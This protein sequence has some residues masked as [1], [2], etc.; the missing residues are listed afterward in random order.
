M[1]TTFLISVFGF[2]SLFRIFDFFEN[3]FLLNTRWSSGLKMGGLWISIL[4]NFY[5]F[6]KPLFALIS[7]SSV[8]F[9]LAIVFYFL[10][11]R[12]RSMFEI[13]SIFFLDLLIL[14]LQMGS[15][16][17]VSFRN[18]I[19]LRPQ[20]IHRIFK[21]ILDSLVQEI[22]SKNFAM[23]HFFGFYEQMI[24]IDQTKTK[25]I[26]R[27]K[28]LRG[29]FLRIQRLKKRSFQI[30]Q[31]VGF[32]SL[33]LSL[34]YFGLMAFVISNFGFLKNAGLLMVSLLIYLVGVMGVF[35]LGV[36]RKW[37]V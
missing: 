12:R 34:L 36:K 32:Q 1:L 35:L 17:R 6:Q 11:K 2:A 13:Y 9:M 37:K 26:D 31:Q 22:P 27:V 3:E 21:K 25:I 29:H 19:P 24:Q 4:I 14:N 7:F 30:H 10:K 33:V 28:A 15:S 16:F 23:L 20:I 18:S 8:C 5:F